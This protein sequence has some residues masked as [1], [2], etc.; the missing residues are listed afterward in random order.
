MQRDR[1]EKKTKYISQEKEP[2][3]LER[4]LT[5]ENTLLI[6]RL[7]AALAD[8]HEEGVDEVA[9]LVHRQ[10]SLVL[11]NLVAEERPEPVEGLYEI[12]VAGHLR[13]DVA[14]EGQVRQ[15]AAHRVAQPARA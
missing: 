14:Q 8:L 7:F 1:T 3:R 2:E 12:V 6:G 10:L 15:C 5:I 4:I 11:G 13:H 9:R